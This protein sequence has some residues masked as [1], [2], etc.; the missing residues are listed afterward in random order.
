MNDALTLPFVV[1]VDYTSKHRDG[2]GIGTGVADRG[3]PYTYAHR[4]KKFEAKVGGG[5]EKKINTGGL[6]GAALYYHYLQGREDQSFNNPGWPYL[7]SY[8]GFPLHKEHRVEMK[9]AGEWELTPS[10]ALR[11]GLNPFYGWVVAHDF[12]QSSVGNFTDDISS[13]GYAWGINAS[14]GGTVKFS[15]FALEPFINGGYRSLRLE[16]D[17][18]QRN[19]T[20]LITGF[21]KI[22][23]NRSEWSIGGGFSILFDL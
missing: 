10:V 21:R 7:Y 19:G 23:Q 15:R 14:L 18:D 13:D 4:E 17:G 8:E 2:D 12:K 3:D 9:F 5:V 16:G 22:D 11:M 1:S 6:I 20:G